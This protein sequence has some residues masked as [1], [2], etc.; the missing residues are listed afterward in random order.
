SAPEAAA[1]PRSRLRFVPPGT[2]ERLPQADIDLEAVVIGPPLRRQRNV[3]ADRTDGGVIAHARS[4]ADT[5]HA[6]RRTRDAAAVG[7]DDETNIRAHALAQLEVERLHVRAA[8]GVAVDKLGTDRLVAVAPHGSAA[9]GI[10]ALIRRQAELR[11]AQGRPAQ[12]P[13]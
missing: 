13:R 10:E 2:S 9:A 4:H 12:S 7:K 8:H 11:S 3:E 5:I 6:S 1:R